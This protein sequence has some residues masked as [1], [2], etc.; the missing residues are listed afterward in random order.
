MKEKAVSFEVFRDNIRDA[1]LG[2]LDDEIRAVTGC[3]SACGA[4]DSDLPHL[5]AALDAHAMRLAHRFNDP[6]SE[7]VGSAGLAIVVEGDQA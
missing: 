2:A 1:V 4:R 7:E 5:F 3:D 6:E